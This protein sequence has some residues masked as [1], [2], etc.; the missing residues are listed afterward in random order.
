MPTI[1]ESPSTEMNGNANK[2]THDQDKTVKDQEIKDKK[3]EVKKKQDEEDDK[4]DSDSYEDPGK[5][6][7]PSVLVLPNVQ[8]Q[9]LIPMED[10]FID[11]N[12]VVLNATKEKELSDKNLFYCSRCKKVISYLDDKDN[13]KF[14]ALKC[15]HETC[16]E[17]ARNHTKH[18]MEVLENI[19]TCQVCH[20]TITTTDLINIW[21]RDQSKRMMDKLFHE[22]SLQLPPFDPTM[23][24]SQ[25]NTA[26]ININAEIS[27]NDQSQPVSTAG[28]APTEEDRNNDND[29]D[30][31]GEE[32]N[33]EINDTNDNETDIINGN[34]NLNQN[35]Q[36]M[37]H[38]QEENVEHKAKENE[39]IDNNDKEE[40]GYGFCLTPDCHKKG[41]LNINNNKDEQPRLDCQYCQMIWCT[42]C[43]VQW[44]LGQTC[45]QYQDD[46][47]NNDIIYAMQ[48]QQQ[49]QYVA[50]D[51]INFNAIVDN[52]FGDDG[53]LNNNEYRSCPGC[54]AT[55]SKD[56]GCNR[57][58]CNCGIIFCWVCEQEISYN[59][60]DEHYKMGICALN[61]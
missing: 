56:G 19:P 44:H 49:Q 57:I 52:A 35:G 10:D 12:G 47:S 4:E 37:E 6:L 43:G 38:G 9:A 18:E 28:V 11:E 33:N 39:E 40:E 31:N 7:L 45:K 58:N 61:D 8:Y 60:I 42:R 32:R 54:W 24:N 16:L 51:E 55:I 36:P 17:C 5:G 2:S 26:N 50:M 15:Q 29:N 3:K 1:T 27:T 14:A 22:K 30:E 21:G 53:I 20:I 23:D 59:Q 25:N 34:E 41:P 13:G 46:L 48:Q